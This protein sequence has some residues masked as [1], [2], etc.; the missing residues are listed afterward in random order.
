MPAKE[1][2]AVIGD[3]LA[4]EKVYTVTARGYGCIER[5]LVTEL[6]SRRVHWSRVET[7]VLGHFLGAR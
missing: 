2:M 6:E 3:A 5:R 4:L 7:Q 1:D